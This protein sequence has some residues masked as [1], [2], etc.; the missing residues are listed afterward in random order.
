MS[1]LSI[2]QSAANC[3]AMLIA[4]V[5]ILAMFPLWIKLFGS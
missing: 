1:L 5:A 3:V 2:H 4:A